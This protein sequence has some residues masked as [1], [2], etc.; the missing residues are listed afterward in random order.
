MDDRNKLLK[1]EGVFE[2][3]L[4]NLSHNKGDDDEG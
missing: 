2:E 1:L 3:T 4:D